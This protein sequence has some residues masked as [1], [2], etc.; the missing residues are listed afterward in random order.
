MEVDTDLV[1]HVAELARLKLTDAEIKRF[2]PQLKEIL[3]SFKV[4]E[5]VDTKDAKP[6]FHPV[7]L[8]NF[9]REDKTESSL[10]QEKSLENSKNN[11][12]GYF[13]GPKSM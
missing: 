13:K 1:K 8:K 6:A 4:L 3:E 10:S 7:D 11:K 5:E 2:T 9:M 12:D